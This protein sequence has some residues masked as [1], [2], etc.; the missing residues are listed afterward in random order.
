[1][2]YQEMHNDVGYGS[3]GIQKERNAGDPQGERLLLLQSM[4]FLPSISVV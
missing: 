4:G 2:C 3:L 1:M